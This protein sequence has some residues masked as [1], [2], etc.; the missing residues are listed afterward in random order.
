MKIQDER[1]TI[2]LSEQSLG[3]HSFRKMYL[4]LGPDHRGRVQYVLRVPA[5][6]MKVKLRQYSDKRKRDNIDKH[7]PV[8]RDKL[9]G[10]YISRMPISEL[11]DIY[12]MNSLRRILRDQK[13]L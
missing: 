11:T 10:E 7:D 8:F 5:N 4:K 3:F 12:S 9:N 1:Q 2:I 13:R 6:D